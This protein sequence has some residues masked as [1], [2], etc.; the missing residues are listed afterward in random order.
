MRTSTFITVL[1]SCIFLFS[2]PA[3]AQQAMQSG[4]L[5]IIVSTAEDIQ[6]EV[7]GPQSFFEIIS[8]NIILSNLL[9]GEYSVR[10]YPI[11]R[12]GNPTYL[13]NQF[14]S[15]KQGQRTIINVARNRVSTQI[16][17]DENS[18]YIYTNIFPTNPVGKPVVHNPIPQNPPHGH[19]NNHGNLQHMSDRDFDQLYNSVKKAITDKSKLQV[20]E[21]AAKYSLFTTR[22]IKQIVKLFSF[23]DGK[24]DCAKT[25][26]DNASD[27]QNLYSVA[28]EFTFSTT[29][30]KYLD[31][32]K[33]RR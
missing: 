18:Q 5:Q 28:D 10:L 17:Y 12:R 23:D 27:R 16:V 26:S 13:V 24:L 1:A 15:V 32:L 25:M 14:F 7:T 8:E 22:Q 6:L 20:V 11:Q 21:T 2:M 9:P 3:T 19:G 29:K 30:D 4:S 31:Y 33:R